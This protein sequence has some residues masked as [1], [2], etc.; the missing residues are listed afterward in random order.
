[1]RERE[2]LWKK[3]T[4]NFRTLLLVKCSRI[5][6]KNSITIFWVKIRNV[7]RQM[8]CKFLKVRFVYFVSVSLR[9]FLEIRSHYFTV[10]QFRVPNH[11][12]IS[13]PYVIIIIARIARDR[14]AACH[15]LH[16]PQRLRASDFIVSPV[17]S[18]GKIPCLLFASWRYVRWRSI[19]LVIESG[20]RIRVIDRRAAAR[21]RRVAAVAAAVAAAAAAVALQLDHSIDY[22]GARSLARKRATSDLDRAE[23]CTGRSG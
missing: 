11:T 3:R 19:W 18:N 7:S 10:R 13:R 12:P 20:N 17:S 5:F 21:V 6:L 2:L 22:A 4:W 8:H 1:M 15:A 9:T 14:E 16:F 23:R